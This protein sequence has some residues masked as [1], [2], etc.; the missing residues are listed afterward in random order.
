MIKKFKRPNFLS[1]VFLKKKTNKIHVIKIW[2]KGK[3]A[4]IIFTKKNLW[5]PNNKVLKKSTQIFSN[6]N[7]LLKASNFIRKK[8][9]ELHLNSEK[10]KEEKWSHR[11]HF[12]CP[13]TSLSLS[14]S[15]I[16]SKRLEIYLPN[17]NKYRWDVERE[18]SNEEFYLTNMKISACM[19]SI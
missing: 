10:K 4:E 8:K 14:L 19:C 5:H 11:K 15:L 7:K 12:L 13:P 2:F 6:F 1:I 3:K 18:R 17:S 16:H 9:S